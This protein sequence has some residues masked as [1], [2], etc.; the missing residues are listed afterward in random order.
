MVLAAALW[1]P[2][3]GVRGR[4]RVTAIVGATVVHPELDG[5]AA[6]SSD[7]TVIIAGNRIKAVG[8]RPRRRCRAAPG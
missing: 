2:R 5:A 8:R 6:S 1:V 7:N 3:G 4:P